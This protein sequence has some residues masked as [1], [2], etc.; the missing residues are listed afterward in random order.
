MTEDRDVLAR[1][2][3]QLADGLPETE[4]AVSGGNGRYQVDAAGAVFA[5]L[6]AVKRQQTVY[7]CINDLIR[8]GTVHAVTIVARTP[9]E[10]DAAAAQAQAQD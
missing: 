8:E 5:G 4:I 3:K 10:R 6:S 2:R 9:E 7:R 1:L